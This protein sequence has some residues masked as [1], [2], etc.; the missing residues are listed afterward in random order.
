MAS[1]I[2]TWKWGDWRNWK[3]YYSTILYLIIGDLSCVLLTT[4]KTL[5]QFE[6]PTISNDFSE[7]LIA[8]ICFPCTCLVFFALYAKVQ[9]YRKTVYISLFFL[10]CATL[11]TSIEWLSFKLGFIT[12]HNGWS[13]YWSFGLNFIMFPLLLLHYKKSLLVWPLSLILA[14]AMIYWFDLPFNMFNVIK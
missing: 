8:F 5:W 7:F 2:I 1:V 4:N 11:Y 12:Y 9:S 3:Q 6:S 10:F 13:L 14:A